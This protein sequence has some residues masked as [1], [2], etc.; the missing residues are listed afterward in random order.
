MEFDLLFRIVACCFLQ[1]LV[2]YGFNID[3]KKPVIFS[4]P[5]GSEYFGYSV[6]LHSDRSFHWVI[7][8]APKSNVTDRA[9]IANLVRYGAAFRCQYSAAG[10]QS[11]KEIPIDKRPDSTIEVGNSIYKSEEK[12]GMWLGAVVTSTGKDGKAMAC[13]PRYALRTTSSQT[14]NDYWPLGK[15]FVLANDLYEALQNEI[16]SPCENEQKSNIRFGYCQAGFSAEYTER[17]LLIGAVGAKNF[18]G[19][20]F[21]TD[22]KQTYFRSVVDQ[23]DNSDLMGYSVASGSFTDPN[24]RRIEYVGGAP[25]ADKVKG[26]VIIYAYDRRVGVLTVKMV[27]PQP[28]GLPIGTYYGSAVLAVDLNKDGHMDILVGA[29]YYTTVKDEGRVFIYLN[30]GQ[31]VLDLQDSFLEGDRKVSALFGHFIAAVGDLNIDGYHDVAIGA[32]QEEGCGAVYIYHGSAKG[33]ELKYRQKILGSDVDPGLKMFGISISGGLDVDGNYYNDIAVGAYASEKAVIL[34][35]RKIVEVEASI[36]LSEKQISLE[37][38]DSMCDLGGA[39]YKCVNITIGFKFDDVVDLTNTAN[40]PIQYKVDLDKEKGESVLRRLFFWNA[41][42][43]ERMT[44]LENNYTIPARQNLFSLQPQTVYILDKDEVGDVNSPLTF[45]LS[46]SLPS[47][48]D[49]CPVLN[50]YLPSTFREEIRFIKKCKNKVA[51]VPDLSLVAGVYWSPKTGETTNLEKLRI[52]VVKDFTVEMTVSNQ[53][54]DYAYT[55]VI[56]LKHPDSLNFIGPDQGVECDRSI[57]DNGTVTVTCDVGNPLQGKA[58]KKFGI[59]FSPGSVREDFVIEIEAKSQDVDANAKDNTKKLPV[60]VKFETDL[61]VT[62]SSKQDRVVY[63]GPVRSKEEVPK[64]VQSIGPEVVHT[65]LVKNNGPSVVDSSEVNIFYPDLYSSSKTDSYLLYL[66]QIEVQ[67]AGVCD[68][69]VNRLDIKTNDTNQV[70][71][72]VKSRRRRDAEELLDCR[73]ASCSQINCHLGMLKMDDKVEFKITFRLWQNTLLKE[74]DPPR[75]VVLQTRATLKVT[76]DKITQ[77]D[78]KNDEAT[79]KTTANPAQTEAQEKKTPWWVIFLSV[80][81]GV[82]LLAGAIAILYKFGFFKRKQ[83]KDISGPDTTEMTDV[84]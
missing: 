33:I 13:A 60:T 67:G 82:I 23:L 22:D 64:N 70:E 83:I 45:D 27:L 65:V 26:K 58:Q 37:S 2:I 14:I 19:A 35:S 81:G 56:E 51:C 20:L 53:A 76:Q 9:G 44:V 75:A 48:S 63:S 4:G 32:P 47:C 5:Q 31:G 79:I 61:E 43:Q 49:L 17:E 59:K 3:I 62:G 28:A 84:Q 7:V 34:R 6:A 24:G 41:A 11:C 40:L 42:K 74:L 68:A 1:S 50:D 77:T 55:S 57:P 8:G 54:E 30:N 18:K 16:L 29:P 12:E 71:D 39:K 78:E 15:C 46:V 38:N 73:K 21:I 10:S 72:E 66:L 69:K 25:R 52:G 36:T 80:L